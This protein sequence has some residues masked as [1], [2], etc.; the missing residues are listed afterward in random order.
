[1]KLENFMLSE[2][3]HKI[4][5]LCETSSLGRRETENS[6]MVAGAGGGEEQGVTAN[7]YK[8]SFWGDENVLELD[9]GD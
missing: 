8:V 2:R 4:S 5:F 1:M 6:L 9:N 3:N 7:G